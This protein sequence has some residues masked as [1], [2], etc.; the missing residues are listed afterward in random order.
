MSYK[1]C[2]GL[3]IWGNFEDE[4]QTH[5][6]TK[7]AVHEYVFPKK[8]KIVYFRQALQCSTTGLVPYY[9]LNATVVA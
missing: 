5:V 6:S 2:P 8:N 1:V 4:K 7:C 3:Y 9:I